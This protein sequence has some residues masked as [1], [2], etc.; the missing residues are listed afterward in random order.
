MSSIT[1]TPRA[2]ASESTPYRLEP[3][4][5]VEA[6]HVAS[7]RRLVDSNAEQAVLEELLDES[8]PRAPAF[9]AGLDYLLATPFR[10]PPWSRGSRFRSPTDPG[11]LYA[12]DERR[13]ACA[14]LG[15]WRWRFVMDS[16]GLAKVGL[17]P[18]AHTLFQVRVAASGID[19]RKK[20]FSRDAKKW[21]D[22]NN[23]GPTQALAAVVRRTPA[24]II[25]YESVRDPSKGGC[26]A[27]LEPT[28]FNSQKPISYQTWFLTVTPT[29]SAW[30]RDGE[31]FEFRWA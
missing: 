27:I 9:T 12:A 7:T 17:G 29:A 19:L 28:A 10:Y 30:Q 16:S 25:R 1:W 11:V 13:A 6:Q 15:Y 24:T 31:T 22:P 18:V 4:R 21:T 23:Y 2:V 26:V 14:E 3:W 20:P 8:K 5:A